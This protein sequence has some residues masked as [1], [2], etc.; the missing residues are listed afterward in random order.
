[1]REIKGNKRY[2]RENIRAHGVIKPADLRFSGAACARQEAKGILI[3]IVSRG[4]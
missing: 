3:G 4:E 1:M 2:E